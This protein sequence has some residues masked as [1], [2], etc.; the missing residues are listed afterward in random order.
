LLRLETGLV[1]SQDAEKLVERAKA[2]KKTSQNKKHKNRCLRSKR[3]TPSVGFCCFSVLLML[4][5]KRK[6]VADKIKAKYP[7]RT[8]VIVERAPKSDAPEIDKKKYYWSY[9]Y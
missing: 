8:P 3:N 5:E 9:S 1:S 7:D 6:E 2:K 4:A